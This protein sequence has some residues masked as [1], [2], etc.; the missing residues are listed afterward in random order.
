MTKCVN[1]GYVYANAKEDEIL[2]SYV[3][4]KCGCFILKKSEKQIKLFED[5]TPIEQT[6]QQTMK[7]NYGVDNY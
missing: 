3:C 2:T 1:C 7:E 4:S 5:L 6:I